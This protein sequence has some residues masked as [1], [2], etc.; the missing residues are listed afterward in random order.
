[1][2][3]EV[4]FH[5]D[6]WQKYEECLDRDLRDLLADI[7]EDFRIYKAEGRLPDYFGRDAPYTEPHTAFT[8]QLMHIHIAVPPVEFNANHFQD[9]RCCPRGEPHQDAALVYCRGEL[10]RDRYCLLALLWPDAH[11]EARKRE[12]M[13]GLARFA[14]KW[15]DEN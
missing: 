11:G 14:Q 8:A 5:P 9:D 10:E 6:L 2:A 15:R 12:L 4:V 13:A 3:V 7:A 1:M